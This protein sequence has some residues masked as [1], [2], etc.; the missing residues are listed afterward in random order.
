[1]K[2]ERKRKR[3]DK[4]KD[5]RKIEGKIKTQLEGDGTEERE[6]QV[7]REETEGRRQK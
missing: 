5:T 2:V 3:T 7:K 6:R 4:V 1:M